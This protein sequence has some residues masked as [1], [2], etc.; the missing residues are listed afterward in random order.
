MGGVQHPTIKC[1]VSAVQQ[2]LELNLGRRL[3][4]QKYK[5][6]KN[7]PFGSIFEKCKN[8]L[9]GLFSKQKTFGR[10]FEHIDIS[11]TNVCERWEG[12]FQNVK[13]LK[14]LSGEPNSARNCI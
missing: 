1:I 6:V 3:F 8:V 11:K 4:E 5:Y 7:Q 9:G 14:S 12:T 10:I 2:I 13:I